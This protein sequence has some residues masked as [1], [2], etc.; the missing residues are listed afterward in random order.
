MASRDITTIVENAL[1][2]EII[3]PFFAVEMFFDT[4]TVRTWT[5]VGDA[6]IDGNTYMNFLALV[7]L[8]RPQRLPLEEPH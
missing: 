2:D 3:E 8:K 1:D 7:R 5:G 6:T 4:Q